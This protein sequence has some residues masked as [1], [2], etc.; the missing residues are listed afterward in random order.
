[1]QTNKTK[2]YGKQNLL[3]DFK[4]KNKTSIAPSNSDSMQII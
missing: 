3:L 2:R 4:T 1:M